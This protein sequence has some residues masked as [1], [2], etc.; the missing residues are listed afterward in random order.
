MVTPYHPFA[1][2]LPKISTLAYPKVAYPP[3]SNF[4]YIAMRECVARFPK[5]SALLLAFFALY[6]FQGAD[7]IY[8]SLFRSVSTPKF[9]YATQ[10]HVNDRPCFK[11]LLNMHLSLT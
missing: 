5:K 8:R 6:Y 3:T 4:A 1:Q 9:A 7:S 10:Y 11:A 2:D